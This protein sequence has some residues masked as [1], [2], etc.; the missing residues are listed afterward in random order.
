MCSGC[1]CFSGSGAVSG[2]C[3][4]CRRC[5]DHTR[6]F[7]RLVGGLEAREMR[8]L[9]WKT[10]A[11]RI[12]LRFR[13]SALLAPGGPVRSALVSKPGK[14]EADPHLVPEGFRNSLPKNIAGLQAAD[15]DSGGEIPSGVA[16]SAAGY[17]C[18]S[19]LIDGHPP[20]PRGSSSAP[21]TR[22]QASTR[23]PPS[24]LFPRLPLRRLPR[25]VTTACCMWG[26]S[27]APGVRR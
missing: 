12:F 16:W 11:S 18:K 4:N 10:E 3:R 22:D 6:R 5:E 20:L 21:V 17:R 24:S 19:I 15:A 8:L 27:P 9:C 13:R 7:K 25:A 1:W 23:C 2:A 14:K 26:R